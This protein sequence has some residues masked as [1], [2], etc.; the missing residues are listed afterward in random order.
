MPFV[1]FCIL[2]TAFFSSFDLEFYNLFLFIRSIR[3]NRITF[4]F[5]MGDFNNSKWMILIPNYVLLTLGVTYVQFLLSE[6]LID[7]GSGPDTGIL[8]SPQV[9]LL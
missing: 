9:I 4:Y 7:L 8:Y 1:L 5:Y 2:E 3:K 6:I